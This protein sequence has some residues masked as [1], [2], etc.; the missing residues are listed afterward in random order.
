[1]Y[2]C[3]SCSTWPLNSVLLL[4]W[5]PFHFPPNNWRHTSSVGIWL[6]RPTIE[7]VSEASSLTAKIQL[8]FTVFRPIQH[9][10]YSPPHLWCSHKIQ[11][12]V[13]TCLQLLLPR[14]PRLRSIRLGAMRGGADGIQEDFLE[15]VIWD[16]VQVR[17]HKAQKR[18]RSCII[19]S[20]TQVS[21]N[22]QWQNWYDYWLDVGGEKKWRI[23]PGQL[24]AGLYAHL[25]Q[26]WDFEVV[27]GKKLELRHFLNARTMWTAA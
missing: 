21:L 27:Q 19:I 15:E 18:E 25:G 17:I 22:L 3:S 10:C 20:F 16:Q 13:M 12:P 26:K 4:H 14:G 24:E 11:D 1:M 5:P 7:N 8:I 23:E 9:L 2:A 6:N